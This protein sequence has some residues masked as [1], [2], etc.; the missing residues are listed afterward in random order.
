MNY[1]TSSIAVHF[2]DCVPQTTLFNADSGT[3]SECA[4]EFGKQRSHHPNELNSDINRTRV[5]TKSAS[6]KT[7]LISGTRGLLEQ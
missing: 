3:V 4:P 7:P 6:V 2:R 1:Y 5:R